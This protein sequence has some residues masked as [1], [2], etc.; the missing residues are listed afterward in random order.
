MTQITAF[1]STPEQL[2]AFKN[3]AVDLNGLASI[4]PGL[5]LRQSEMRTR[6]ASVTE[7]ERQAERE[8]KRAAEQDKL[9]R[10]ASS[11]PDC[12]AALIILTSSMFSRDA[13]VWKHVDIDRHRI[14][15]S[16]ILRDYTFSGGQRR[17]LRIA[18]SLFNAMHKTQ[19]FEDLNGLDDYN[20]TVVLRAICASVRKPYMA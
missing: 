15:F 11:G 13:R 8:K 9:N 12:R 2:Q 19:L 10:F 3:G 20:T 16:R 1:F 17:M 6:M 7:K 5:P 18:A 4:E 14:H